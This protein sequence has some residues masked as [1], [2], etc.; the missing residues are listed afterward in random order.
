MVDSYVIR[1]VAVQVTDVVCDDFCVCCLVSSLGINLR[2]KILPFPKTLSN[3]FSDIHK[4]RSGHGGGSS[5]NESGY[6]GGVC[7]SFCGAPLDY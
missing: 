2:F 4:R 7:P 5:Q 6:D 1:F 3:L